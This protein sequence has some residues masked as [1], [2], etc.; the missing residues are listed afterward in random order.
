VKAGFVQRIDLV[1]DVLFLLEG[2]LEH[3]EQRGKRRVRRLDGAQL[4]VAV[5][6]EQEVQ[7]LHRVHVLFLALQPQPARGAGELL[8][9]APGRT[10]R[11]RSTTRSVPS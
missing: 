3:V 7:Q 6:G 4:H 9:L 8:A 1:A 5:A 11:D 2:A 10:Y